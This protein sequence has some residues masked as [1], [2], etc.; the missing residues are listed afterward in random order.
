M[1]V[2]VCVCFI[3]IRGMPT[4]TQCYTTPSWQLD[5]QREKGKERKSTYIYSAVIFSRMHACLLAV[6]KPVGVVVVAATAAEKKQPNLLEAKNMEKK[7][8]TNQLTGKIS[9]AQ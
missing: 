5:T 4:V 1:C 7:W 8:A 3:L 2:C 6:M 9:S